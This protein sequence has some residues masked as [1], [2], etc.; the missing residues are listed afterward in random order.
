MQYTYIYIIY[1]YNIYIYII[2]IYNTI[3]FYQYII[4]CIHIIQKKLNKSK[5][6]VHRCGGFPKWGYP[7]TIPN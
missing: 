6:Q 5:G 4:S 3:F 1:I 7:Q 2:Y